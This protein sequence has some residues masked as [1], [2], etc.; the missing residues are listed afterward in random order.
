MSLGTCPSCGRPILWGKFVLNG[1]CNHRGKDICPSCRVKRSLAEKKKA[2]VVSVLW[3][4]RAK[5]KR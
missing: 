4:R 3:P 5:T 2:G 1:K